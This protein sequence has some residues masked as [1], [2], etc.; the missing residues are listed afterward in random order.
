MD[1]SDPS[2]SQRLNSIST[3]IKQLCSPTVHRCIDQ[4]VPG[5]D[6]L[7]NLDSCNVISWIFA[8]DA[9]K[10]KRQREIHRNMLDASEVEGQWSTNDI[11]TESEWEDRK[12]LLVRTYR[13][14][15]SGVLGKWYCPDRAELV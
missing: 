5:F 10:V 7:S 9:K 8:S 4:V 1:L 2:A 11:L 6:E 15:S 3:R 12:A 14:I 13:W